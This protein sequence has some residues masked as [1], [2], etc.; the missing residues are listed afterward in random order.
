MQT[1]RFSGQ[2]CVALENAWLRLLVAQSVGPR[3]LFL[4]LD[5][6][7]NLLA[8]LPDLV[9]ERPGAEPFHFYGGHRLWAAPEDLGRTYLPDDALVEI[10]AVPDGLLVTQN[11]EPGTGLQKSIQVV[12]A[13]D[14]PR[15]VLIHRLTNRGGRPVSCAPWSI[16]QFRTG[17]LA[18]LPQ[19]TTDTGLLP[20]RSVALWPYTD[21]YDEAVAWG[22]SC[23]L[24]RGNMTRPFKL[25][26]PNP[27]GWLA[28]WLDGILFVKHAAYDPQAAY[29]DSGSSS[30]FYCNNRFLELE[31]LAPIGTIPP[32]GS[33]AHVETWDLYG[34]IEPPR[35]EQEAQALT[36]RLRLE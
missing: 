23:I 28:Y 25:G 31:T 6:S 11:L 3:L 18:I 21:P 14:R 29:Y 24:V 19:A 32:G 26:F 30:E 34:N 36:A 20:N 27:R 13:A 5:G 7:G 15:L 35:D 8:E 16:T 22:K 9:V 2:A 17:G 1:V 10:A 12:L 33:A 4:G